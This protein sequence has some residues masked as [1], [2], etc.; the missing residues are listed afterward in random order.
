MAVSENQPIMQRVH[1]YISTGTVCIITKMSW[2]FMAVY[3]N[4]H[5]LQR[6]PMYI[7]TV[8]IVK[9]V[10]DIHGS[11]RESAYNAKSTS[12]HISTIK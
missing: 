7:S 4:Q 2:I 9:I 6:V 8:C 10:M 11:I 5:I 12:M 1:V 3:E